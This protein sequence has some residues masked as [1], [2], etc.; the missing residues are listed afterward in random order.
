MSVAIDSLYGAYLK[1][2]YPLEYF[3]VALSLYS[4]DM[5]RT[6][7]LI[8][9]MNY[10][11]IELKPIKFRHSNAN[12]NIEKET[13]SIYKGVGAVKYCNEEVGI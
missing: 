1:A 13:N 4:G 9:E 11:G 8:S 2:H 6:A 12:Y 10:L 3:T 5:N 7:N